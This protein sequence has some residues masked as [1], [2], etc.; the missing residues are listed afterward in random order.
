MFYILCCNGYYLVATTSNKSEAMRI[1][2]NHTDGSYV[3]II[4]RDGR[5]V[6][7]SCGWHDVM[8]EAYT[9]HATQTG[10]YDRL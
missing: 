6:G 7:D 9:D 2:S 1:A 3:S 5:I 8:N 4:K 10:M